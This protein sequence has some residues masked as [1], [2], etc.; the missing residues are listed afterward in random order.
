MI[1]HFLLTKLLGFALVLTSAYGLRAS[2]QIP[3]SQGPE[4][5]PNIVF[6][7]AD[8]LGYRE[9]GSFGQKK[10]KTPHLDRL[11]AEGMRLTRHYSGSPVCAPSRCVL[12]TGKHP[13]HAFVRDNREHKPEGQLPMPATEVTL[14]ERL[15][16]RGYVCGAFGKWGLGF[17]GSESDPLKKG[18][19]RFFGYNCQRHAHSFYPG[20]LWD[21]DRR[22]ELE[23]KPPV[24]GHAKLPE[25]VDPTDP[26]SYDR[27]KGKDYAADRI[28]EE[29]LRFIRSNK[30]KPFFAY[31]PTLIPHLALHVPDEHLK[32]YIALG[33]D[34][35]P[36]AARY[37]PHFTPR[38]AY[39]AM[40]TRLD[41]YVGRILSLLEELK[42]VDNTIVVFTS[43]NGA[44]YLGPMAKFFDSVG[45]LRGFKGQSYEGGIRVPAIVRF[46][47]KVKAGTTSDYL[48]GFE[49]WT[50]TLL[51]LTGATAAS[52]N[53]T[54]GVDFSSVLLGKPQA[55]R[56]WL[57]REFAGYGG[58]QALWQGRWKAIR[59][60][61]QRRGK[62]LE[63]YDLESDEAERS[64]LAAK[65]PDVVKKM[66]AIM[67][68]Q[69]VPS[70][71][72]PI[73]VLDR[74]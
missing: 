38:A 74:Q 69:H 23:N 9:L 50:P 20:Y 54:D 47:G 56:A 14:A 2:P 48:S 34:D 11:A 12:M 28:A 15:K 53:E 37:T 70:T 63:L 35:P 36:H 27:Y 71:A 43:D 41:S 65:H 66:Q 7:L 44:T 68:Q 4:S 24:P 45:N 60:Q 59:T 22:L 1:R 3:E 62:P 33:W 73:K 13:G 29:V 46:P 6:I 42:L 49:D 39:A 16:K 31:Y 26:R 52:W 8:D 32:P 57:Y 25:G 40:I 10:I 67:D 72:F 30:G 55:P 61:L 64:D 51:A 5:Q 58:Q 18:F 21:D 17:P 19:D